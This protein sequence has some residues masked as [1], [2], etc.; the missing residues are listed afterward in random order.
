MI[1]CKSVCLTEKKE[2]YPK[3]NFMHN[4]SSTNLEDKPRRLKAEKNNE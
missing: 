2:N 1:E 3:Q 4:S